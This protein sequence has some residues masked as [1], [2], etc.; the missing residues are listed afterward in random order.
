MEYGCHIFLKVFQLKKPNVY[1]KNL[2]FRSKT[3][4]FQKIFL[5]ILDVFHIEFE[6]LGIPSE[7]P[8]ILK[9]LLN[10]GFK[11]ALC[12]SCSI[13]IFNLDQSSATST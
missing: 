2:G 1:I 10:S 12:I 3:K 7:I 6:I 13:S 5:K 9:K 11:K 8:S 4:V